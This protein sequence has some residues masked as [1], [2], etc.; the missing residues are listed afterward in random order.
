MRSTFSYIESKEAFR[1]ILH[2]GVNVHNFQLKLPNCKHSEDSLIKLCK[3]GDLD[4]VQ[5]LLERTDI[6]INCRSSNTTPLYIAASYGHVDVVKFLCE[7]GAD[8]ELT[9]PMSPTCMGW[10]HVR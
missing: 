1:W 6:D 2:R 4:L 5:S 10:R 3:N 9:D 7:H 8:K